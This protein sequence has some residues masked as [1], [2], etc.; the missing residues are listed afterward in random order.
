MCFL[1][2]LRH[3]ILPIGGGYISII[4]SW[5]Y[6]RF[7]SLHMLLLLKNMLLHHMTHYYLRKTLAQYDHTFEFKPQES[8]LIG[9]GNDRCVDLIQI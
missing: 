1:M 9:S 4:H 3:F 8:R 7:D 5:F 2:T 6:K